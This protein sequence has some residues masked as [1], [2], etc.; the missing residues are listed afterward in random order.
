MN[1]KRGFE[2][3]VRLLRTPLAEDKNLIKLIS[4]QLIKKGNRR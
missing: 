4:G 2:R 1:P 3:D